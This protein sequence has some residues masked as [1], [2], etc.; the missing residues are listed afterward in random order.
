MPG[1]PVCLD[2]S[3]LLRLLLDEE[4]ASQADVLWEA[5]HRA[6]R[7][8]VAPT[9]LYYE[10]ANTLHRYAARGDLFPVEVSLPPPLYRQEALC[11][12]HPAPR[13]GAGN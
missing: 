1:S 10:V 2:A 9:L 3:F 7:P 6:G 12:N 4:M 11:S 8:L 5:W 13:A